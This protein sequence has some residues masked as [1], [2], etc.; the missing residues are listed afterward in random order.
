MFSQLKVWVL[1]ALWKVGGGV[2][3]PIGKLIFAKAG[4]SVIWKLLKKNGENSG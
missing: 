4:F 3:P 1:N 2:L